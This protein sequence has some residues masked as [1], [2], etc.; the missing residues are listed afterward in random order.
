MILPPGDTA[1]CLGTSVI[2]MTGGSW[3]PVDGAEVCP[4]S[5]SAQDG[6]QGMTYLTQAVLG[7]DWSTYKD[8]WAP[9]PRAWRPDF[10]GAAREAP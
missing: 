9:S 7:G 4:A 6:T 10:P 1:Q 2:V 5:C 8:V 3:H